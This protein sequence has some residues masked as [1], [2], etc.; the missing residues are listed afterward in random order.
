MSVQYLLP[1]KG[2]F[3]KANLHCHSTC[4]DG[5]LTPA[6]LKTA[7][8]LNQ[9]NIIAFTDHRV[10]IDHSDLN[11]SSFL[12]L[13]GSELDDIT[14]A[15]ETGWQ[16]ACHLCALSETPDT[17]DPMIQLLHGGA[18]AFNRTI[19]QLRDRHF[20]VHYNHPVWTGHGTAD[21]LPMKGFSGFEIYNHCSEI[22]GNEG[23]SLHEYILYLKSGGRAYPVAADDNH[24]R[25]NC[26]RF[27][28]DSFGGFNMIKAPSLN[29][30]DIIEALKQG[31]T[32]AST[33]PQIFDLYLDGKT[34]CLTCTPVCKAI[35]KTEKIGLN[36]QNV[37]LPD[38]EMTEVHFDLSEIGRF[39]CVQLYTSDGR[40]ACTPPVFPENLK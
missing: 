16:K 29:Y 6:E 34:L 32:Y 9:Y 23:N 12:A 35:L 24:N 26:R 8:R 31:H 27:V 28:T 7:Y 36:Q 37:I 11:D 2:N 20:I 17:V 38:N 18:D 1:E 40:F 19:D 5:A 30:H 39:A 13:S 22:Y 4:S 3:Y 21:F 15:E 25:P 10:C 33:G 14:T